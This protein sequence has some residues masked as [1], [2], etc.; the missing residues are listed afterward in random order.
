MAQFLDMKA[1]HPDHLL[2]FRMGDF[3]EMFFEDAAIAA[4]ALGIA[5]TKRGSAGDEPIP[6]CGVPI[7]NAERYL[8]ELIRQGFRVAVAEQ[9]E[10]P[11]EAK[12][13]GYKA[14]VKREIVRLVTPGTLSE[15][16][17]LEGGRHNYLAA[18]AE[19]KGGG[20]LAWTDISTGALYTAI[21]P[22][23][24]LP[25]LLAR[26]APREVLAARPIDPE[27]NDI[28]DEAG[29]TA[30]AIAAS[31][32]APDRGE[33]KLASLFGATSLAAYGAFDSA[34]CAAL[35]ALHDYLDLTQ[36]GRLPLL[37]PPQKEKAGGSLRID[38]ATRRN[39]ELTEA[40]SGGRA[41]SLLATIDRTATAAGARLLEAR[42]SGPS[43][44]PDEIR[45]R[46]DAAQYFTEERALRAS[47]R[48]I[49]RRAPDLER[50]LSRLGLGRGGPRDLAALR[51]GLSAAAEAA[52]A[53]MGDANGGPARVAACAPDLV[54]AAT[55][56]EELA[57][58]VAEEPPLR[59]SDG[60]AIAEGY[61]PA[62]DQ[63]RKLR[64]NARQVIA[65]LQ[66]RYQQDSGVGALKIKHNAVLGY[67]VETPASHAKKM[68][69]EP[70]DELFIHR[71]TMANAVRFTTVELAEL[72]SKIS[73]AA[74]HAAELEKAAFD[75]L[76]AQALSTADA[77]AAA[78]AAIAELDVYAA[79]AELADDEG[80]VRPSIDDGRAFVIEAGRH[81]VV[82]AALKAAGDGPFVPNDADLS[83]DGADA[84]SIW[85]V[86]GPNM[87]GK[88]T[89]LRQN[90][91]IA[92]LAQSG[93]FVP[94]SR[95][96]I[97]VVD[98]LF[99]RVGASDDLARG[100][101]TFMVEMV[102]T[103]AILN[104]AGPRSLVILDEIGRG[105]STYDGLSIAWATL[106]H[107]VAVNACRG[108]FA[109]HYHELTALAATQASL[110]NV[111][112][113]VREWKGD[114]VFLREIISGAADRSYGVQVAK[115]A[116]LPKIV[117]DRAG[118]LLERLETGAESAGSRAEKLV[119]DLPLFAAAAEQPPAT[120]NGA[121]PEV[122]ER[123]DL[124]DP[125][126]MTPREA[127]SALYELKG[128]LKE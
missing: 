50:A 75:Q 9:V 2:F 127:L 117:I 18:F 19:K 102:E 97:G 79:L 112:V 119:D 124:L 98:Q 65:E 67:F 89:F 10:D 128:L 125:D 53:L 77:I 63:A 17:L 101:S 114:V 122:I 15:D 11:A 85:L 87:A 35:G 6:M 21:A 54:G 41:G 32:F 28:I 108:L 27:L 57:H 80:W 68:M 39:L 121:P 42:L 109:T 90:A 81:P 74:D 99:S 13:R 116:G 40:L 73:R 110:R 46:L 120:A 59:L 69:S 71:Q 94:A 83:A 126:A 111:T 20:A 64:E 48:S 44:D 30:S 93:A 52:D 22:R 23:A 92:V 4:E 105:T 72:E 49:L 36:R 47:L 62:L 37:R 14:V 91:L 29:A 123:L 33:S 107:L 70:M 82:E 84:Q 86:T 95:A 12:K 88:S 25:A 56:C 43:A 3:Y 58:A 76:A 38:A 115:L 51:D 16:A 7:H 78:A 103:A 113:S 1:A 96:H 24:T 26:I 60:G 8:H 45:Q 118:D 106:E 31:S 34:E 100:R 61:D 104:Q 55:L 5:L 66:A